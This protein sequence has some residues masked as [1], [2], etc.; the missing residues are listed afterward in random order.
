M[1]DDE[2]T[3]VVGVGWIG[4]VVDVDVLRGVVAEQVATGAVAASVVRAAVT[5]LYELGE[6]YGSIEKHCGVPSSTAQRWV[7]GRGEQQT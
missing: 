3:G 4:D 5:R 1:E 2:S 7:R 6:S